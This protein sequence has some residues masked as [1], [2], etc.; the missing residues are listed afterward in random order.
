MIQ[1]KGNTNEIK[2]EGQ[3][4]SMSKKINTHFQ[5]FIGKHKYDKNGSGK[6]LIIPKPEIKNIIVDGR[7]QKNLKKE[8]MKNRMR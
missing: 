7:H 6:N 8:S 4:N 3:N 2:E 5:E 1:Q